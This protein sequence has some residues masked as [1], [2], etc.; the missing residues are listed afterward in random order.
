MLSLS[1]RSLLPERDWVPPRLVQ[2]FM[3]PK[4]QDSL[5]CCG[6]VT[7]QAG[8]VPLC[9]LL[10]T[11]LWWH[12]WKLL[13]RLVE[14]ASRSQV[15]LSLYGSCTCVF[16]SFCCSLLAR[17]ESRDQRWPAFQKGW[18]EFVRRK[19]SCQSWQEECLR[20]SAAGPRVL[21]D[22][23]G[24]GALRVPELRTNE[25]R[26]CTLHE[27]TPQL[28]P[29]RSWSLCIGT[30][31]RWVLWFNAGGETYSVPWQE[32]VRHCNEPVYERGIFHV[33]CFQD[34]PQHGGVP[35]TLDLR[36]HRRWIRCLP[37]DA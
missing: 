14:C 3:Y 6:L 19:N 20:N 5:I 37:S 24:A 26:C 21:F 22:W 25:L 35:A 2:P 16:P 11:G 7:C 23:C 15:D 18:K 36:W 17:N 29:T 1:M 12:P 9:G 10:I 27:G 32:A 13:V 8:S 33:G 4:G 30:R 34:W 31:P 28:G